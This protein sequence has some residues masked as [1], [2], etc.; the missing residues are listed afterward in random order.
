[1]PQYWLKPLGV[2]E[3]L[4]L[5]PDDWLEGGRPPE[6][7]S[8]DTGPA[9]QRNPPQ[10]G[11]GDLVLLHAVGHVRVF[12][13]VRVTGGPD[14]RGHAPKFDARWPWIYHATVEVWVPRVSMGPRTPASGVGKRAMGAVQAGND[15][16]RLTEAQYRA[17]LGVLEAQPGA[18]REPTPS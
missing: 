3:P 13:Q 1:M 7:F 14:W 11:R 12:A 15:Y 6:D 4:S 5:V 17:A 8:F 10:I 18:R 2:T 9:Q 16:A